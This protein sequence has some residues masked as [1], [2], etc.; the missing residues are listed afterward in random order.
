MSLAD[1]LLRLDELRFDSPLKVKPRD[2]R[3]DTRPFGETPGQ[4]TAEGEM[5]LAD[6]QV[7]LRMNAQRLLA[8]Q[9]PDRWVA[10]SGEGT[11]TGTPDGCPTAGR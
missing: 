11:V 1:D 3:I 2:S 4:L 8:L 5:R 9:R 7:M 10:A 6:R